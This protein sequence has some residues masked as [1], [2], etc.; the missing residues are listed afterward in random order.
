MGL[1]LLRYGADDM[2]VFG[3]AE[4]RGARQSASLSTCPF[5]R[6]I[7]EQV[8]EGAVLETEEV[9]LEEMMHPH[10]HRLH[11]EERRDDEK[12]GASRL[13]RRPVHLT[14]FLHPRMAKHKR[15]RA[16]AGGKNAHENSR[17]PR[18]IELVHLHFKFSRRSR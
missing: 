8:L 10:H 4:Q 3:W 18:A 16:E 1:H 12:K 5:A 7:T 2:L 6:T 13:E 9:R 11:H 14:Y 15:E 17:I